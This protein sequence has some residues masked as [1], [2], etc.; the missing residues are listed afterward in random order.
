[1][2]ISNW[3]RAVEGIS[4]AACLYLIFAVLLTCC[5]GGISVLA[6]M[7]IVLDICFIGGMIAIAIMTR[8][9]VHSCGNNPNTPIGQGQANTGTGFNNGNDATYSVHYL[10]ACRLNKT[11]FAISIIAALLFLCTAAL[12][13]LLVRH[14]KKEKRF[15]P[16]PD[17]NYT[18]G[19]GKRQGRFGRKNKKNVDKDAEL[20]TYGA[21]APVSTL[22]PAAVDTRPS[23][24]TGY[25]GSTVDGNANTYDK[26]DP[27]QGH[28]PHGTHHG[29][30]SQPVGTG[31]NPYGYDQTHTVA[32]GT[33][34][35]Y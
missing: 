28:L 21:G 17:N 34:T 27:H 13:L 14:H 20:G 7:A 10:T 23:H 15:G 24:E 16:G 6:F 35:N 12:Q 11:V 9:A 19:Y 33:A 2:Q 30:H 8:Q 31:V 1:M 29:Y 32:P 3:K 25:T 22:A 5:F 26:I 18:S 4:G